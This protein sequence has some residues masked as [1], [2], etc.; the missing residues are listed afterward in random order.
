LKS[1]K[2]Q[3]VYLEKGTFFG[4]EYL[5]ADDRCFGDR[6]AIVN[7]FDRLVAK[8]LIFRLACKSLD[9]LVMSISVDE[10]IRMLNKDDPTIS[11]MRG[12]FISKTKIQTT[13]MLDELDDGSSEDEPE[14]RQGA[15]K[16]K[17]KKGAANPL[18]DTSKNPMKMFRMKQHEY[19]QVLQN[20]MKAQ[21]IEV[22]QHSPQNI[23]R[24]ILNEALDSK[25]VSLSPDGNG[26]Q[27]S[28]NFNTS[29]LLE[30]TNLMS[31]PDISAPS[32]LP[33]SNPAVSS[34]TASMQNFRTILLNQREI[35]YR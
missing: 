27:T 28:P 21:G 22:N 3:T 11:K 25:K 19:L 9:G 29:M 13:K 16:K 35:D 2:P 26:N 17:K 24:N 8:E 31:T 4:E 10:F 7:T 32:K 6:P 20:K 14:T 18:E 12:Q 5:F 1:F 15:N 33:Q 30:Q 34:A 23:T